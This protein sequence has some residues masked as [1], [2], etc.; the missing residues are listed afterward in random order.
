MSPRMALIFPAEW[1]ESNRG[2]PAFYETGGAMNHKLP[3][4]TLLMCYLVAAETSSVWAIGPTA[5]SWKPREMVALGIGSNLHHIGADR[6]LAYD[7]HGNP[8]IAFF[9]VVDNDL[10]YARRV[11]GFGWHYQTIDSVGNVGEYPSLAFDRYERPAISYYDCGSGNLKFVHFDGAAWGTPQTVD[12]DGEVGYDTSLAFD[13]QGRPGIAY[14]DDTNTRLKFVYDTNGDFR[15]DDETPVVVSQEFEEGETPS[16]VFDPLGRAMIAHLDSTNDDLRFSV[17][18]PGIGWIT[19]TVDSVHGTGESQSIAIDP[20][21]G[22]PAIAYNDYMNHD[23]RYAEWDGN[24]WVCITVDAGDP[25]TGSFP[26][27]AFDTA[28]GNPAIAYLNTSDEDLMLAWHDGIGWNTQTVD[29]AG[30]VGIAPS[31]AFNDYG[32]GYPA[33]AYFEEMGAADNIYFIEDPPSVVPEPASLALLLVAGL[34]LL[35]FRRR[36]CRAC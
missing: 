35:L 16:L 9:D 34:T 36:V 17:N 32:T 19:T 6:V 10:N 7:H 15:L 20:D 4:L 26:S 33:I 1:L 5:P 28:D 21:T 2:E 3:L 13:A 12:A 25:W 27:L 18:E 23:L 8:G 29:F 22:Y 31:L 14:Y 11:P 30:D 24:R